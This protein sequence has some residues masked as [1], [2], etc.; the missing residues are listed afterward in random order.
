[1]SEDVKKRLSETEWME[2]IELVKAGVPIPEIANRFNVAKSSVYR[3]LKTR[4][5]SPD[6]IARQAQDAADKREHEKLVAKIKQTKENSFDRLE[7][8]E[9]LSLS[10]VIGQMKKMND[11][12]AGKIGFFS[13]IADDLKSIER[14]VSIVAKSTSSKWNILGI[15]RENADADI[16]MPELVVRELT[17]SEIAA[18]RNRQEFEG[19]EISAEEMA[20]IN[21]DN[22]PLQGE[23]DL[24]EI[25][26]EDGED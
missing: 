22:D 15:N 8:L 2:I 24:E 23:I 4:G 10:L 26:I 21:S 20:L 18:I 9:K 13:A 1:M 14:A 3:G 17:P 7:M 25:T 12:D 6:D 16:T 19:G 11:S 5:M